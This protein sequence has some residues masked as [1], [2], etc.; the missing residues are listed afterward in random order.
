MKSSDMNWESDKFGTTPG[1]YGYSK[2][3]GLRGSGAFRGARFSETFVP[4][5]FGFGVWVGGCVFLGCSGTLSD[6]GREPK[7]AY[8]DVPVRGNDSGSGGGARFLRDGCEVSCLPVLCC[9]VLSFRVVSVCGL[10]SNSSACIR[11]WSYVARRAESDKTSYEWFK[12][13]VCSSAATR[14]LTEAFAN[15]SGCDI[16]TDS[17][18]ARLIVAGVAILLTPSIA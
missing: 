4:C 12:S 9:S 15:L 5:C 6:C 14:S 13:F 2:D 11:P 16:R 7:R 1:R 10:C 3:P 18:Y 8:C 17:W